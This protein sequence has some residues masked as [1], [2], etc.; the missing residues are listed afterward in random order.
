M[1]KK[2][3]LLEIGC[4]ELPIHHQ[5]SLA[6][7]LAELLK[8]Q[9]NDAKIECGE[10]HTYATPRRL[11]VLIYDVALTQPSQEIARQGQV[12]KVLMTNKE[13]QH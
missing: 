5:A 9:L 2:D 12:T 13:H 3:F 4:E 10:A 7:Q 1:S 6:N 11:A 8:Q